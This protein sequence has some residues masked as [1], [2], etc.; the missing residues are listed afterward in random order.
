M[1]AKDATVYKILAEEGLLKDRDIPEHFAHIQTDP[2][3][4]YFQEIERVFN[5]TDRDP[6]QGAK[7]I[8]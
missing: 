3:E 1:N 5:E 6:I 4:I 7:V 2:Q 8:K